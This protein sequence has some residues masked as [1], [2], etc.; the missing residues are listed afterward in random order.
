M[1]IDGYKNKAA[2]N[3]K[4]RCQKKMAANSRTQR[5]R[6]ARERVDNTAWQLGETDHHLSLG[7]PEG[8]QCNMLKVKV[9]P[10]RPVQMEVGI[11]H[12]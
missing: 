12:K 1:V 6:P 2:P 11:Q 3:A 4:K 8:Q 5:A 7:S 10:T 9:M